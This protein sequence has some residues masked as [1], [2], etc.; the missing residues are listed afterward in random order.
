[1]DVRSM[2]LYDTASPPRLHSV[3]NTS[4]ISLLIFTAASC[5]IAKNWKQPK[6]PTPEEDPGTVTEYDKACTQQIVSI[7]AN[8]GRVG[9]K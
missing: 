7:P 4:K 2:D 8:E 9:R 1:M 6:R 3:R 5:S